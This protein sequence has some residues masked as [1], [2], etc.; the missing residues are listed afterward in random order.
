MSFFMTIMALMSNFFGSTK[1]KID[2][3]RQACVN[4]TKS[5]VFF[6][7]IIVMLSLTIFMIQLFQ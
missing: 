1:T 5:E 3:G 2:S 4:F 7:M 6:I